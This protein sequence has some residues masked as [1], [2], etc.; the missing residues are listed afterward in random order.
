MPRLFKD[1]EYA[2]VKRFVRR[3]IEYLT[4]ARKQEKKTLCDD[5]TSEGFRLGNI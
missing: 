4:A 2:S 5:V 3:V 1:F